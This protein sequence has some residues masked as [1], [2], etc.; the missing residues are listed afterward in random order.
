[1]TDDNATAH[2]HAGGRSIV[3]MR[4]VT[5]TFQAAQPIT[6][7]DG[8]DLDIDTGSFVIIH[9][10]SGSGKTTLLN[11]MGGLDRPNGGAVRVC[12]LDLVA[13]DDSEVGA[14][15]RTDVS[16]VFQGFGLLPVLSAAEN[17]EV[18]LR[19]LRWAADARRERVAD[20]LDRVGLADRSHHRPTELSGGEQQRIAIARA[21][22][23]R[24]QLLI[25]DEPTGQLDS[26]TGA[27]IINL[28]REL[29]GQEGLTAVVATHDDRLIGGADI[30]V[31]MADG[32]ATT[33]GSARSEVDRSRP[34]TLAEPP[35]SFAE[36][37]AMP[38]PEPEGESE[39]MPEPEPEREPA[40]EPEA[41]PEREPE[42]ERERPATL[43]YDPDAAW[44]PPGGA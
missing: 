35:I 15:R 11:V 38:E 33:S 14:L 20:V 30:G 6:A 9:G 17:I 24:P 16:Y 2:A 41:E 22:A 13:A 12:G 36:S 21:I 4:S 43:D 19:L 7:L 44:R 10:R 32:R 3:H 5:R 40:P 26:R 31:E 1:M 18:P 28:L 34:A 37:E 23:A 27:A 42:A 8:V 29:V 39:A 25:A